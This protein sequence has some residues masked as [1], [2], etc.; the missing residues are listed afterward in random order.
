MN[1]HEEM[2]RAACD[3][4]GLKFE[5]TSPAE[6]KARVYEMWDGLNAKLNG[7]S[8]VET[9][10][11]CAK[12]EAMY[13]E[14][15]NRIEEAEPILLQVAPLTPEEVAAFRSEIE[16]INLGASILI[17]MTRPKFRDVQWNP[18][19]R[20]RRLRELIKLFDGIDQA[21]MSR[22]EELLRKE[23]PEPPTAS[24]SSQETPGG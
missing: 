10:E 4:L 7:P 3:A 11:K 1:R 6:I 17:P 2:A 21:P 13:N 18:E 5:E 24:P 14:L 23:F 19:D 20:D 22:I 8:L 12:F 16:K 15:K 9:L